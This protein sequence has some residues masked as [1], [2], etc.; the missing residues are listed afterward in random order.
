MNRALQAA[1]NGT[2]SFHC[3]FDSTY[4]KDGEEFLTAEQVA[5]EGLG[6]CTCDDD[7]NSNVY[8]HGC[9]DMQ[10][11][12][13]V[14]CSANYGDCPAGWY[15]LTN[16]FNNDHTVEEECGHGDS[17]YD[18][19]VDGIPNS[20]CGKRCTCN[21]KYQSRT[22][23]LQVR[24]T[25]YGLCYDSNSHDSYCTVNEET[26]HPG[27]MYFGPH[28]ST[29]TS[30]DQDCQC[31]NVHVGG[32]MDGDTFSH[33]A[34]TSDN[35]KVGQTHLMPRALRE[36][37]GEVDCRLCRDD[38]APVQDPVAAPTAAP[39]VA[40]TAAPVVAPTA[41]P[42]ASETDDNDDKPIESMTT[43]SA[44]LGSNSFVGSTLAA[45]LFLFM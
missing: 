14:V 21:F 35:C 15:D 9:Y 44:F 26:C 36:A 6:A 25:Q 12:H 10:A 18:N 5:S 38:F 1:N 45:I 27:E 7:Y 17:A 34:V 40:P 28:S 39:V 16:R 2:V 22:T 32:C 30:S 11:T 37:N 23:K 13:A 4:C 42:V 29:M 41:A 19:V 8:I 43:S 31:A 24:S 3:H 33:C 20:S